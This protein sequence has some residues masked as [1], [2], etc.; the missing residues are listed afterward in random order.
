M[1]IQ[2]RSRHVLELGSV[3]DVATEFWAGEL[4]VSL[5]LSEGCPDDL[6]IGSRALVREFTKIYAVSNNLVYLL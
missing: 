2:L 6:T 1:V 4:G 3:A 5:E